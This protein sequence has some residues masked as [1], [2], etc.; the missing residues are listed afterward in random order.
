MLRISMRPVR[1][2]K[3]ALKIILAARKALASVGPSLNLRSSF[4]C[5]PSCTF[6]LLLPLSQSH[7]Y[8]FID[9]IDQQGAAILLKPA[10]VI[11]IK[12]F[13]DAPPYRYR[14]VVC[15]RHGH[16]PLLGRPNLTRLSL[17]AP[18]S[19]NAMTPQVSLANS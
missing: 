14:D 8:D 6:H 9:G 7:L 10:V 11:T 17:L 15:L 13:V 1:Y 16:F 12:K 18:L 4:F 2:S 3:S 19:S 5:A